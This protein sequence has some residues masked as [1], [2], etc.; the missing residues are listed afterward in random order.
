MNTVSLSSYLHCYQ[1]ILNFSQQHLTVS[2]VWVPYTYFVKLIPRYF[3]D[4]SQGVPLQ[5]LQI[6]PTHHATEE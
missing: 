4:T 2:S 1:I 6:I 3:T 5:Y